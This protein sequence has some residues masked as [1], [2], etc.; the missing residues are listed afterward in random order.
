[1]ISQLE[2][3]TRAALCRLLAKREPAHQA[4]WLTEAESWS[5]LSKQKLRGDMGSTQA[6]RCY[7]KEP[8]GSC[9]H[10]QSVVA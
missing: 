2:L 7:G 9:R 5:R 6:A 8:I 10:P 4:L 1:M 3:D